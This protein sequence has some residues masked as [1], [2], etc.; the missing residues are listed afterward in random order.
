MQRTQAWVRASGK[1]SERVRIM[2]K[3]WGVVKIR[4]VMQIRHLLPQEFGRK[5]ILG[6]ITILPNLVLL[7]GALGGGGEK[8]ESDLITFHLVVS[9]DPVGDVPFQ[10]AEHV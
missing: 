2:T 8:S 5:D 7:L 4:I 10:V 3:I 9:N 1:S 6:V